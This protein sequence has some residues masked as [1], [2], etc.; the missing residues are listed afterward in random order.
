[1]RT[2]FVLVRVYQDA[3]RDHTL[4][5]AAALA[6][7][8]VLSLFPGLI[9]LSVL[10]SYLP[11]PNLFSQTIDL[12]S[13]FMPADT[14]GI[15]RRVLSDIISPNR[16]AFL[17]LGLIG[18]LWTASGGFTAAIEACG[19]AYEVEDNRPFWKVRLLA[20]GLAIVTEALLLLSLSVLV[21]G[22][23]FGEW[24][25][26]ELHLSWLLARTWPY[27]QWCTALAFSVVAVEIFYYYGPNV[28]QRFRA[29]LPGAI[30]SVGCWICLSYLLGI[31][32]RHFANFNKTYGTLGAAIALMTTL[33]WTSFAVLIG[34]HLN[35]VLAK[36]T[37]ERIRPKVELP[38]AA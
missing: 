17:S 15:V 32:F 30:L 18:T 8:L 11:V 22:P 29:T 5:M 6:Y 12:M 20:I 10:A 28:K 33:Y 2:R 35:S 7:Y 21:V 25:A 23:R 1:M 34:A 9:V 26:K 13:R 38:K 14:M 19:I 16:G 31:Y 36:L 24:L 3:M 37:R 4:Q 27:I